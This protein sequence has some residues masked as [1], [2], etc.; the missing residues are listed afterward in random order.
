MSTSNVP[1]T[2]TFLKDG[3]IEKGSSWS[4]MSGCSPAS[5][6]CAHCFA[7]SMATRFAGSKAFPNG[8]D[9][10]LFPERLEQP[11]HWKKP[12]RIFVCP[13]GDLFHENV[14]K[15][16]PDFIDRIFAVMA[17]CPQHTF[18]ILTKRPER[19]LEYFQS[20]PKPDVWYWMD[21]QKRHG[22]QEKW[23]LAGEPAEEGPEPIWPL[24]NVMIGVTAENQEMADKRIP[25]LLET[26][27]AIRFVSV[28]PMLGPV[29]LRNLRAR[30]GALI[31]ALYGD[32]KTP[33]G[34]E[35]YAA[36]P[37]TLDLVICGAESG[38]GKRPMNLD[39]A[40]NLRDQCIGTKTP[41]FFK[42]DSQGNETLD[43]KEWRQFPDGM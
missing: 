3:T 14:D 27:A 31:D 2:W 1:W 40:R 24:P 6:G 9:V 41:Y 13:T 28:E 5:T 21:V 15:L 25:I 7:H 37:S 22:C 10:T 26:P 43:G 19:M 38:A 34:N 29:G 30:N 8:F 18:Q 42:K 11:L 4:P 32:V 16:D 33:D 20:D 23:I 39:W 17:R 35:V 36:C 12:R